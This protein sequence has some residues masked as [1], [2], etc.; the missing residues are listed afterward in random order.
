MGVVENAALKTKI[1]LR[2]RKYRVRCG[3]GGS[4]GRVVQKGAER[5]DENGHTWARG[6][7]QVG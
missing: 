7:L 6:R 3:D 4:C 1:C 5:C 2:K